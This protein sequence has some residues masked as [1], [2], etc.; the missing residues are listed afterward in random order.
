MNDRRLRAAAPR[1]A[2]RR[3]PPD[4]RRR[5]PP[6][7]RSRPRPGRRRCPGTPRASWRSWR[8]CGSPARAR[9]PAARARATG[10][11]GG[12]ARRAG[13]AAGS[14]DAASRR[15]PC[16]RCDSRR[17]HGAPVAQVAVHPAD[18][19]DAAIARHRADQPLAEHHLRAD[20]AL[21]V[22]AAGDGEQPPP[23]LVDQQHLRVREPEILGDAVEHRAQQPS[24]SPAWFIRDDSRCSTHSSLALLRRHRGSSA[25][26]DRARRS[27]V[28]SSGASGNRCPVTW[29]TPS[30]SNTSDASSRKM[31]AMP[32]CD[33]IASMRDAIRS[34]IGPDVSERAKRSCSA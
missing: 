29:S 26:R 18:A 31:P 3:R 30:T 1:G 22:A 21:V 2:G 15:R 16:R 8:R 6:A 17:A 33:A 10:W 23:G 19:H 28:R 14:P 25:R 24:R 27:R 9:R 7:A 5:P 32:V 11:P 13:R 34:N 12:S 4:P 20:A